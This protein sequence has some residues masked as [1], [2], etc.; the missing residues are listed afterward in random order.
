MPELLRPP[1]HRPAAAA[2]GARES[3]A[4]GPAPR[5]RRGCTGWHQALGPRSSLIRAALLSCSVQQDV[6]ASAR[7]FCLVL[8]SG[9]SMLLISSLSSPLVCRAQLLQ[10][11]SEPPL[12]GAARRRASTSAGQGAVV[13]E[14]ASGQGS[15]RRASLRRQQPRGA[16]PCGSPRPPPLRNGPADPALQRPP[17]Q[18]SPTQQMPQ[19]TTQQRLCRLLRQ[20]RPPQVPGPPWHLQQQLQTRSRM[21]SPASPPCLLPLPALAPLTP[22]AAG[23][24]T[25]SGFTRLKPHKEG[26]AAATS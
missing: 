26:M 25:A 10:G 23:D 6:K 9:P 24:G 18:G 20:Q 5:H 2:A 21:P 13:S 7:P 22:R 17:H 12:R 19:A 4:A 16:R 15:P 8:S 14:E 11:L 3:A 1:P